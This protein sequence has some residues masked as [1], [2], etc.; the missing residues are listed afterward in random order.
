MIPWKFPVKYNEPPPTQA[1]T[2]GVAE[3]DTGFL[4]LLQEP[5]SGQPRTWAV[6]AL[7]TKG[8]VPS[9]PLQRLPGFRV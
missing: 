3:G 5:G 1:Q 8:A 6:L 7:T 4:V 9:L 2:V